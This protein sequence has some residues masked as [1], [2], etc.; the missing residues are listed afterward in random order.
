MKKTTICH[1]V[2]SK[3]S[4]MRFRICHAI[5]EFIINNKMQAWLHLTK[6]NC[7][8]YVCRVSNY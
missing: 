1:T 8:N 3:L 4:S 2:Y 7:T 5:C 6:I